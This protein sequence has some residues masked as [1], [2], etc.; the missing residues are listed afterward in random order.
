MSARS[1][2][3]S[4]LFPRNPVCPAKYTSPMDFLRRHKADLRAILAL[5]LLPV[6][7]YSPALLAPWTGLTI[8]PYD[9]LAV[10]A[11]WRALYPEV[12]PHNHAVADAILHHNAWH[13]LLHGYVRSGTIPL[14]NPH[15]LT[16]VPFLAGGEAGLLYPL[17]LLL[18]LGEPDVAYAAYAAMH[19]SLAGIGIYILGRSLG[20]HPWAAVTAGLS[21][22]FG[23][24]VATHGAY[25]TVLAVAA[26]LPWL[27]AMAEVILGKQEAKGTVS[28]RPIPYLLVG[29]VAIAM[30]AMAGNPELLLYAVV[31]CT[32]YILLRLMGLYLNLVRD[33]RAVPLTTVEFQPVEPPEPPGWWQPTALHRVA[34]QSLWLALMLV[35]GLGMAAVQIIPFAENW[36]FSFRDTTATFQQV[37]DLAWPKRQLLT[38]WIPNAFGNPTHHQWFDI[39]NLRWADAPLHRF[40]R[41][42]QSFDFGLRNYSVGS[43][44]VGLLLWPLT[45]LAVWAGLQRRG[46]TGTQRRT[47]GYCLA[48]GFLALS[49]TLGLPTYRGLHALPVWNTVLSAYNWT[50]VFSFCLTLAGAIGCQALINSCTVHLPQSGARVIGVSCL[51]IA[52]TC[53]ILFVVA[54]ASPGSLELPV[55]R[56]FQL[57]EYM[58]HVFDHP[59]MFIGYQLHNL[60]HLALVACGAGL[61]LWRAGRLARS[62]PGRVPGALPLLV[63]L[64]LAA[65]LYAAHG[66]YLT[67][68]DRGVSPTAPL[69]GVAAFLAQ[70]EAHS[71][72]WRLTTLS[73]RAQRPWKAN[74]GFYFGWHD[75]RGKTGLIPAQFQAVFSELGVPGWRGHEVDLRMD[76][77]GYLYSEFGSPSFLDSPLLDLWNVKY[78]LTKYQVRRSGWREVYR[79]ADAALYENTDVLPRAFLVPAAVRTGTNGTSL[80]DIDVRTTVLLADLSVAR[81]GNPSADLQSGLAR[82]DDYS[83]NELRVRA[84]TD[85]AAWMV[86]GDAWFPGWKAW[87]EPDGAG[88]AQ[89]TPVLRANGSLRAIELPSGFRGH[90]RMIYE[91]GSLRMGLFF[92]FLTAACALMMLLWWGWGR[93]RQPDTQLTEATVVAKNFL[94]PLN[95]TLMT[96]IIDFAFA[97]FYVRQLGPVGTGQFAFVVALY[98]V[99]ELISRFGLD[100]LLTRDVARDKALSSR[101]L[102][103]VCALRTLIWAG[104]TIAMV[105]VAL[106]F[107]GIERIT[108]VEVV[109][110]VIFSLAML[111][112]GWSD[113]LSAAFH[114]WEKME[115]PASLTTV[116]TL[117]RSGLGALVLLLGWGLPGIAWVAVVTVVMQVVWF[118]VMLRRTLFHWHWEWDWPL[119]R[120]MLS[121]GF[122]FMLNSLLATVLL[123]IDIWILRLMSGEVASGLYSVALK[124]RF[125][126]TLIPSMFNFA[127]FPLFS[128]YARQTGDGLMGAYRLSIRLLTLV[129]VPIAFGTTLLAKPLVLVVGGAEFLGVE[130]TFEVLGRSYTF[131]GGSHL[132]LQVV[133]WTIVFNF[134]NAVTQYVLI[135]LD[136]QRY[137]TKAF[138]AVVVFNAVGNL[139]LIPVFGYTGAAVVTILSEMFLFI[140]FQAGIR[141]H[142]GTV[143][144]MPLIWKP[145]VGLAVMVALSAGLGHLGWSV[146]IIFLAA[147]AAYMATLYA[148]GEVRYLM[149]RLPLSN[150]KALIKPAG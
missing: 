131:S 126:I 25:P 24:Y 4:C 138:I 43:T 42:T 10:T 86:V 68:A 45:V 137:L 26:W 28:F 71:H 134:I 146:W 38:L 106:G 108:D 94:V 62:G 136:Q 127:I 140:P 103:N 18:L 48:A 46:L 13:Y 96:R 114:A 58:R 74:L 125:G 144:W 32:G 6:L 55:E 21:W 90:V 36:L 57:S 40:G 37:S 69:P 95:L 72:E 52:A 99:F 33:M 27:L 148:T 118:Y 111:F 133:I 3:K 16:G 116:S 44:Y 29:A 31:F 19:G 51:G 50:L 104:T 64:L 128:R 56:L 130:E 88:E 145:T 35:L 89:E 149:E 60:L 2:G 61:L 67:G 141:R 8:L 92:S 112:A 113:A 143:V 135:A 82:L 75:L 80:A 14:W 54:W 73:P 100:T 15:L 9:T 91:P 98:G 77:A 41:D 105:G 22:A 39:W 142:L 70:R 101:Y 66:R 34:K 63:C 79:D 84:E 93:W 78:L 49:F 121:N 120:W 83:P 81:A 102:T 117:L 132:A 107:R 11:P 23:G 150:L 47:L 115:Y 109:T 122:P 129:S 12:V 87:L 85:L 30:S 139:L 5:A 119:Q 17:S 97:M 7:W 124:Y 123:N 110:I 76:R 59:R 53:L 65:D 20:F 147:S 1:Q